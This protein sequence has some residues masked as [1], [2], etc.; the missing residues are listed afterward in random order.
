MSDHLD[1]KLRELTYRLI[2]MAPEAPPFPEEPMVQLEPSPTPVR[3]ARRRSPLVWVAAAAAVALLVVG[4]PLLLF[5]LGDSTSPTVPPA[6][7][8]DSVPSTTVPTPP[9]G[10]APVRLYFT[11]DPTSPDQLGPVLVPVQRFVTPVI[12]SDASVEDATNVNYL[13]AAMQALVEGP[14]EAE[15]AVDPSLGTEIPQG[16]EV[17]SMTFGDD[18]TATAGAEEPGARTRFT[19]NLS[20][21]FASGGGSATMFARL[22]QVVFTATQFPEV[23]E[24]VFQVDGEA[25]DVFSGERIVLDGPQ[26]RADWFDDAQAIYVDTPAYGSTVASPFRIAGT[27]NVFEATLQY[28]IITQDGAVL[29]EGFTTA[30]CGTGCWGDFEV[31]GGYALDAETSGFV[32]VFVSSPQDGSRER[33]LS[34]PLRL[35]ASEGTTRSP[36]A[37][38]TTGL[39]APLVEQAGLP[40]QVAAT[41][42]AIY[43]AAMACDIP[44]LAALAAVGDEPFTATFGG[45]DAETYWTEAEQRN[46]PILADLVRHLNLPYRVDDAADPTVYV[47]PSAVAMS[48]ATG[49]GIPPGDYEALLELYSEAELQNMF[50]VIG[51]YVGWRLAIDESGDWRYFVQGD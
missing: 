9:A 5:G 36:A 26:T 13:F 45:S 40:D 44:A 31:S 42:Q 14:T 10:A 43:A 50:D 48:S 16:T 17:L 33:V 35:L 41:R 28:E 38:S 3:P 51:G 2:A 30:T 34:Y 12:A 37:C 46:E 1:T 19:V 7:Q 15:R 25:V 49:E 11:A 23:T 32:N 29:A 18:S 8:P 24:V 20:G 22:R 39:E 27:A 6:T 21:D 47:W 4:L